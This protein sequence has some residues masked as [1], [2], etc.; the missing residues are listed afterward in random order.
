MNNDKKVQV[1][2]FRGVRGR[3]VKLVFVKIKFNRDAKLV[4]LLFQGAK[5]P[6]GDVYRGRG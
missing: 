3:M 4:Y 5:R 6:I 2:R 1:V